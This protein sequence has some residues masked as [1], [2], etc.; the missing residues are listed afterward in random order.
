MSHKIEV[1]DKEVLNSAYNIRGS[2]ISSVAR[3]F[4]TSQPTVRKWLIEY[5]IERKTHLQASTEANNRN[6]DN[7][8]T[9]DELLED[10]KSHSVDW[11]EAKYGVGQA[12]V[13]GWLDMYDIRTGSR[14]ILTSAMQRVLFERLCAADPAGEWRMNDRT[15]IFP[16]ELDIVSD[17]RKVAIEY[18]GVYWHS[19]LHKK[20]RY[21]LDKLEKCESKGYRL[22]TVFES[23]N[24]DKVLGFI[25]RPSIVIGA[26]ECDVV[27]DIDTTS[28]E[29]RHHLMGA[30]NAKHNVALVYGGKVVA[31]MSF[32]RSRY[33]KGSQW[34]MIR[35]TAGDTAISGGNK[36]LLDSFISMH[37]PTSIITYCDRRYGTG[38][39]YH[40]LGFTHKHNTEPNYWY[41]KAGQTT[42]LSR[43]M[44]MKHK[45]QSKLEKYDPKKTER[46]NMLDNGYY[47]IYDCGSSVWIK[48]L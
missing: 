43:Q 35:Y 42:L 16:Q 10:Y 1:P 34:E 48:T 2:T 44:F 14:L 46:Q 11:I 15:I 22:I 8:P 30:L 33:D 45:L 37:A 29:T 36:R 24:I 21:H 18:C 3:Q 32:S 4:N 7:P 39:S 12:T 38:H 6:R 25:T 31:S 26:R 41:C 20:D 19:E 47:R 40:S 23:D 5:G 27:Y 9:R 28:F 13:Y 17:V